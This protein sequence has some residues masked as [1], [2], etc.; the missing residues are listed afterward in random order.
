MNNEKMLSS[1]PENVFNYL[2]RRLRL[3]ITKKFGTLVK[4]AVIVEGFVEIT[5]GDNHIIAKNS[6]VNQGLIALVNL[7]SVSGFSANQTP[8]QGWTTKANS[9]MRVGQDTVTSTTG[10][11]IA[12][13][14]PIG[15]GI[16]TAPNTQTIANSNPAADQW[17]VTYTATWN[18]GTLAA[19]TL[20]EVGLF[21]FIW[22]AVQ[23]LQTAGTPGVAPTAHTLFSRMASADGK[24]VSFVINPAA[25][26][27]VTWVINFT[28]AV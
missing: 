16:G 17:Q 20:G 26:V 10:V 15:A 11:M 21:L 9:S 8:A 28:F 18:A 13:Q 6:F 19:L 3:E 4:D 12:L 7:M 24:F 5:N 27:N 14:T 1:K 22:T 25:A 23:G 2:Y